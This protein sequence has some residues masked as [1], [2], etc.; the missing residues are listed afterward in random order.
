M[1]TEVGKL[2]VKIDAETAGVRKGLADVTQTSTNYNRSIR[3]SR[4]QVR[5]IVWNCS[6][7]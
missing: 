4:S 2:L 7:C 6:R 3:I 1:T 5:S